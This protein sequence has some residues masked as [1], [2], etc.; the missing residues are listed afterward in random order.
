[1]VQDLATQ[2]IQ[3]YPCKTKTWHEPQRSLQ[4]FLEPKRNPKVIY[5][6]NS[7]E[8]RKACEDLSTGINSL[9][10]KD[11]KQNGIVVRAVRRVKRWQRLQYCCNQVWMKVGVADSMESY[12]SLR[13]VTDLFSDGGTPY[14]RL[15]G[16]P[17]NG[18]IIPF[19][20]LV[21][22]HPISAKD[23]SRIHH[24][25]KESLTW[26]VPRIRSY[27]RGEF[28]KVTYWLQTLRSWRR[29]THRKS[30][31]KRLNAKEVILPKERFLF[32]QSK[33]D[34]SKHLEEIR[35]WEHPPWYGIDQFKERVMLTFLENQKG[36]FHNLKTH[37]RMPVK[38]EMTFGP[39]QET[40]Y[41]AITLNPESNFSR[42]EKNHSLFHWNTLTYPELLVQIWMSN[43]RSASMIFGISMDL[44]TCLILGQVW[45]NLLFWKKNLLKDICGLGEDY[46]R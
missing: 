17:F 40:S 19:G 11:Q 16:Q 12:T 21:E 41:T 5:T 37:F 28:G 45:H 34:E 18:P 24:F 27:T 31:S 46:T 42:R 35:T 22:Y 13:N 4:K 8:F 32:F 2:W 9:R 43:K 6:D 44:E 26:I 23:Q 36:L 7:L 38:R 14:E 39:C 20:S 30:I 15:F 25:W 10:H 1:M 33:M 3:A 29:W